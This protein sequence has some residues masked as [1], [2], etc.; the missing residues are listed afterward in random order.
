MRMS[1]IVAAYHGKFDR[2]ELQTKHVFVL[3]SAEEE[4]EGRVR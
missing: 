1:F 4:R 2:C 3:V